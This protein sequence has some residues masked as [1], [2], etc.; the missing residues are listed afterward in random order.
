MK[1]FI[2]FS[3]SLTIYAQDRLKRLEEELNYLRDRETFL[4]LPKKDLILEKS[5]E[6]KTSSAATLR[7]DDENAV[8]ML[9]EEMQADLGFKEEPINS[10]E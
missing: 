10:Q 6:V 1:I 8:S 4:Y 3:I 2:V 5:D 9:L 7:P